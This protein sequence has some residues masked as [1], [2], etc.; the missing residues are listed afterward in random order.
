[1]ST[2]TTGA[3]CVTC[4]LAEE[5]LQAAPAKAEQKKI[6]EVRAPDGRYEQWWDE[7]IT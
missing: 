4:I 5:T 1:L 6:T 2:S 3:L 7:A